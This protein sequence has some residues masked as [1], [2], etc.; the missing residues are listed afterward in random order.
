MDD[1]QVILLLRR[2][3]QSADGEDFMEYLRIL[4]EDNYKKWKVASGEELSVCQGYAKCVDSLLESFA[5]CLKDPEK[6]SSLT[7][8]AQD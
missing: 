7:N 3:R 2:I 6:P 4:K 8:W 5:S 1:M